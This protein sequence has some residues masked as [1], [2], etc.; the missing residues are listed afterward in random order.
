[1]TRRTSSTMLPQEALEN[2][3]K[4]YIQAELLMMYSNDAL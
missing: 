3:R 2:R 1:M 4:T